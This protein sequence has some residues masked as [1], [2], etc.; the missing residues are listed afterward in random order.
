MAGPY[1]HILV[2]EHASKLATLDENLRHLCET[3][4]CLLFLGA[5]SPDLPAI[6]DRVPVLGGG[7]WSDRFHTINS[8][9]AARIPTNVVVE[10]VFAEIRSIEDDEARLAGLVWL[11][12]YI[13]HMVTDVVIHPVVRG[14]MKQAIAE[15][16]T[17]TS[18][19]HQRVEI[20]M[21]TMLVKALMNKE[22]VADAPILHWLQ[23]AARDPERTQVMLA[24]S[25]AIAATYGESTDPERWYSS[26]VDAL[27]MVK[28]AP[29]QF[30]GYTYARFSEIA[31]FERRLYYDQMM[32]PNDTVGPYADVFDLAVAKVAERWTTVWEKWTAAADLDGAI[33]NWDL[34]S[35]ENYTDEIEK[36]LWPAGPELVLRPPVRGVFPP[37]G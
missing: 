11:L 27:T 7:D 26:Y 23:N 3:N 29:L 10:K 18:A 5:V 16:V 22:S 17:D 12:G 13:G 35:G 24:W 28:S 25:K 20:V 31:D 8:T 34:N 2:C 36:D 15:G 30:R 6:W 19:L 9:G 1:A 37:M 33:P 32:L 4:D 14:C 21:D